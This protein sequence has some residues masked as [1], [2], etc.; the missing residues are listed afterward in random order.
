[1]EFNI[2]LGHLLVMAQQRPVARSFEDYMQENS[3]LLKGIKANLGKA[4][5]VHFQE[6]SLLQML[7]DAPPSV[8][9]DALIVQTEQKVDEIN[10]KIRELEDIVT[11]IYH[12]AQR[13][14]RLY[15]AK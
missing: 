5:E 7:R 10:Q 13:N 14:Q 9:R 12:E 4:N 2:P 3:E 11:A 1:M 8:E 15:A 6:N